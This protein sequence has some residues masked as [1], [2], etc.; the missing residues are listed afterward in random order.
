MLPVDYLSNE[1]FDSDDESGKE[2]EKNYEPLYWAKK[3]KYQQLY[4]FL[5]SSYVDIDK[6]IIAT[7]RGRFGQLLASVSMLYKRRFNDGD[8]FRYA[9]KEFVASDYRDRGRILSAYLKFRDELKCGEM[10]S[11]DR[12]LNW[13]IRQHLK[14]GD[15][16]IIERVKKGE[17]LAI[18]KKND[19]VSETKE[20]EIEPCDDDKECPQSAAVYAET[21]VPSSTRPSKKRKV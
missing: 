14:I 13:A 8:H 3:G 15:K 21:S 6:T 9:L 12:L 10:E 11:Y 4:D 18:T 2:S 7:P 17:H 20:D 19:N 1:E 16:E 5:W